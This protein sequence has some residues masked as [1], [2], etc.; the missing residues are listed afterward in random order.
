MATL[1]QWEQ[2]LRSRMGNIQLIGEFELTPDRVRSSASGL[3]RLFDRLRHQ[4]SFGRI[5]SKR[6]LCSPHLTD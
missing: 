4:T 6:R 3:Q 1:D 5:K 2:K